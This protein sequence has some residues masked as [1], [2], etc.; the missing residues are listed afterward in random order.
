MMNAQTQF[1]PQ[2]AILP[3]HRTCRGVILRHP[4]D[5]ETVN[6]FTSRARCLRWLRRNG[7]TAFND[8]RRETERG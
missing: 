3:S 1:R 2:L 5:R 4:V 7:W 8:P 6:T